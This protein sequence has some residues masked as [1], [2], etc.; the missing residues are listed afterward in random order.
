MLKDKINQFNNPKNN[1]KH[2]IKSIN[3]SLDL[4]PLFKKR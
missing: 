3:L 4:D 1:Q 2:K